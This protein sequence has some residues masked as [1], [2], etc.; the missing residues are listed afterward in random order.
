MP[1]PMT[2]IEFTP[3]NI[4]LLSGYVKEEKIYLTNA[5]EGEDLTIEGKLPALREA[6]ESLKC[7]K[8]KALESIKDLGS[9]ILVLPPFDFEVLSNID[10]QEYPSNSDGNLTSSDYQNRPYGGPP[11]PER[12]GKGEHLCGL[13]GGL[14]PRHLLWRRNGR[15][16]HRRRTVRH[17]P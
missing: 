16:S 13:C 3:E 11:G 4:R 2:V 15:A 9:V 5:L 7:L 12:A 6:S 10:G 17:L 14:Q 8:E 1:Y